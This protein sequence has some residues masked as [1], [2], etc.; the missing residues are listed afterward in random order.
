MFLLLLTPTT[1]RSLLLIYYNLSPLSLPQR[2][3]AKNTRETFYIVLFLKRP[4]RFLKQHHYIVNKGLWSFA[5]L[6][7]ARLLRTFRVHYISYSK[8]FGSQMRGV[9]QSNKLGNTLDTQT[10][11]VIQ[12]II[13]P[14]RQFIIFVQ[15]L[16]SKL[17]CEMDT[18]KQQFPLSEA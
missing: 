9:V 14:V 3:E 8:N 15:L 11:F 2:L 10:I 6:T 16:S 13:S 5:V 12:K 7:V 18:Q 17:K 1:C 4:G